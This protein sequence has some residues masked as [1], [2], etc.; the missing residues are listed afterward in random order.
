M[1]LCLILAF[2][3]GRQQDSYP[4][5]PQRRDF[6]GP[7]PKPASYVGM[8]DPE[9]DR[10]IVSGIVL[11]DSLDGR[12]WTSERPELRFALDHT[13]NLKL[14]MNLV[15]PRVTLRDTGPITVTF[16]VNGKQLGKLYCPA[17]DRYT[18]EAPVPEAWLHAGADN[19]VVASVDK[20]WTSSED[21]QRL[22]F[23]LSDAGFV[24]R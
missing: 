16:F 14:E 1:S 4:A 10:F 13:A 8:G 3:C 15:V 24:P 12:R 2:S 17:P 23:I 21:G 18:F 20:Y 22:G 7:D 11:G 6:S 9:V 5:P 19:R